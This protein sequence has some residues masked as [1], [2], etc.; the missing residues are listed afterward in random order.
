M[1]DLAA[2][3]EIIDGARAM[4]AAGFAPN[5]SGNI[6]RRVADGF[7]ITPAAL[8]YS[9]LAAPDVIGVGLRDGR[10]DGPHPPSSEWA[11]HA[12]VY[13]AR[14]DA[15]AVVHT[16]S[17]HATALSTTRRGIPAIHYMIAL[18]G[19]DVRCAEYATFGTEALAE[20]SLTALTDRRAALLA[21]H[22]VIALGSSVASALAVAA[23]VENLARQYLLIL[24]AGLTPTLLDDVE[25]SVVIGKFKSYRRSD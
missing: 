11:M 6:S 14:A 23:E 25:L 3:Q 10:A 18:A 9:S 15:V 13:R 5:K 19:G 2:R 4:E 7:L 22:G 1:L 17:P 16:H 8:P 24:S 12:A 21:N 20:N